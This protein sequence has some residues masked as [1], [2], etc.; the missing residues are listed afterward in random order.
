[1]YK[2]LL[3]LFA[4]VSINLL[5]ADFED[6]SK[7]SI[8]NT[9]AES[10]PIYEAKNCDCIKPIPG[11]P[12]APG[13]QGPRGFRGAKGD[14]GSTGAIGPTGAGFTGVSG[15]TGSA[16]ATGATGA[17]GATGASSGATGANGPTGP[18]GANGATGAAGMTGPISGTT[19]SF[20]FFFTIAATG[21]T[22]PSVAVTRG[23]YEV[24]TNS[25]NPIPLIFNQNGTNRNGAPL[26]E[27]APLLSLVA[28]NGPV[29]DPSGLSPDV[30]GFTGPTILVGG[31]YQISFG[32]AF[33]QTNVRVNLLINNS[34]PLDL[35]TAV[36]SGSLEGG[37]LISATIIRLLQAGDTISMAPTFRAIVPLPETETLY[38]GANFSAGITAYLTLELLQAVP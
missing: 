35:S 1:M 21:S 9:L 33:S 26:A 22:G 32:V 29:S 17:N 15:T 14:P 34:I 28:A 20:A 11:P 38:A 31:Y 4:L 10:L 8:Q 6:L 7:T 12:G 36:N 5:Q 25:A 13:P 2:L 18:A 37:N 27:P 19:G 16:G 30:V 24:I 23:A 3:T